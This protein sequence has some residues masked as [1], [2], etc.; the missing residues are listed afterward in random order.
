MG[1]EEGRAVLRRNRFILF[2][3]T[4]VGASSTETGAG[5]YNDGNNEDGHQGKTHCGTPKGCIGGWGVSFPTWCDEDAG[6][7][8]EGASRR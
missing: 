6:T 5:S 1:V 3:H 7:K 8:R 2:R 4:L